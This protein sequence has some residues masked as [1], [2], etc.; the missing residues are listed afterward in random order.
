MSAK[1]GQRRSWGGEKG[2]RPWGGQ[3]VRNAID[4]RARSN[5]S[6][7]RSTRRA[8]DVLSSLVRSRK[9]E[10]YRASA[11]SEWHEFATRLQ[12]RRV[13][14]VRAQAHVSASTRVWRDRAESSV[15]AVIE[16]PHR[17]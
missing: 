17:Q 14:E 10:N 12:V 5:S 9:S 16:A 6:S 15:L 3:I 2:R 4:K 1:W 11:A 7:K 8:R 13:S